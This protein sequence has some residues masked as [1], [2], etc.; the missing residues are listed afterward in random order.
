ML[1]TVSLLTFAISVL[2]GC[3][4]QY[5]GPRTEA[6]TTIKLTASG[7][8]RNSAYPNDWLLV[9]IFLGNDDK[10]TP[11]GRVKLSPDMLTT[12]IKL[13]QGLQHSL[14]L[15]SI[16]AKFGGYTSCS[17]LISLLPTNDESYQIDYTT[18]KV[19]CDATM[20]RLDKQGA[21]SNVQRASTVASGGVSYHVQVVRY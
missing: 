7:L 16:E 19:S 17:F 4:T 3:A 21:V 18:R 9:Q 2:A 14:L 5:P 10:G 12:E 11:L 6:N 13:D 8:Q 20:S 15:S 1:K